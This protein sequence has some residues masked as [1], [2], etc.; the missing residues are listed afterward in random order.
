MFVGTL[1]FGSFGYRP[2]SEIARPYGNP[3]F[4]LVARVL[5]CVCACVCVCVCVCVRL[6]VVSDSL[7]PRGL[8]PTRLLCPWNCPGRN[9]GGGCRSLLQG[10][11]PTQGLNP[12]LPHCRRILY[13]LSCS[14]RWLS[15]RDG[16]S[17]ESWTG[18]GGTS[19]VSCG[20]LGSSPHAPHDVNFGAQSARTAPAGG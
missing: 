12:G 5:V 14:R 9:A 10:I 3:M 7:R 15:I 20:L 16:S 4:K 2:W 1:V 18:P 11:F 13:R 8:Q 19:A 17:R 6:S